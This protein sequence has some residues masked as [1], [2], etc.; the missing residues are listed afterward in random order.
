MAA[1]EALVERAMATHGRI[2]RLID[3]AGQP[4]DQPLRMTR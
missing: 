1:R 2:Q 3:D 4:E